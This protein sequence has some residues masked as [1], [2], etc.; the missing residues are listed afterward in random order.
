MIVPQS[1]R[2]IIVGA[3]AT[4]AY[5]SVALLLSG[6]SQPVALA[7]AFAASA[8][9]SYFGHYFFT[10]VGRGTHKTSGP[11]F[12]LQIIAGYGVALLVSD[13]LTRHAGW[14]RWA[15]AAATVVAI[16]LANYVIYVLWVFPKRD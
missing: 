15:A 13:T 4:L 8:G 12:I 10:F 14:P 16:P 6:I 1:V 5:F 2:Y 9:V 7:I 11:R 3:T